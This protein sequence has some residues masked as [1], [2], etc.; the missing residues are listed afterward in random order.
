M[1]YNTFRVYYN[2]V[3]SIM[4]PLGLLQLCRFPYS[5]W[6]FTILDFVLLTCSLASGTPFLVSLLPTHM[7]PKRRDSVAGL[8]PAVHVS[9]FSSGVTFSGAH[10]ST[11]MRPKHRD[12]VDGWYPAVHMSVLSSDVTFLVLHYARP[13]RPKH[14]DAVAGW[15]PAVHVFSLPQFG[16]YP[17]WSPFLCSLRP[18]APVFSAQRFSDSRPTD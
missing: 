3:V 7:R 4:E 13:L 10:L 16:C 1:S 15:Y 6:P 12:S 18:L 2:F 11:P 8:Y 9:V 5:V 14:R 17:F